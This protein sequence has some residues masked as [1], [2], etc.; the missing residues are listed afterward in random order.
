MIVLLSSGQEPFRNKI[1]SCYAIDYFVS[2]SRK[3]GPL[4]CKDIPSATKNSAV[5]PSEIWNDAIT[6]ITV[7]YFGTCS[8]IR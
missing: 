3:E 7:I 4:K 6:D 2:L 1:M 5:H 8:H